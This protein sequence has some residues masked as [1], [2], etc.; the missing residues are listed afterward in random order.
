MKY[1]FFPGSIWTSEAG[2]ADQ[3]S[4]TYDGSTSQ[5]RVPQKPNAR[6]PILVAQDVVK[7]TESSAEF[8]S[9]GQNNVAPRIPI[10]TPKPNLVDMRESETT[11]IRVEEKN[12]DFSEGKNK[13]IR[14]IIIKGIFFSPKSVGFFLFL[15]LKGS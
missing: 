9:G 6:K 3:S 11:T 14:V 2:N 10:T 8:P 7:T 15:P 5:D 13:N 4:I 12:T 1:P